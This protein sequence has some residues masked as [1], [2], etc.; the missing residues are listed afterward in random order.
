ML[1]AASA[2]QPRPG[3]PR[4]LAISAQERKGIQDPCH[5]YRQIKSDGCKKISFRRC[6]PCHCLDSSCLESSCF[7]GSW[8][9]C[10]QVLVLLNTPGCN[11][12]QFSCC[13]KSSWAICAVGA[14]QTDVGGSLILI[15]LCAWIRD[16]AFLIL[17]NTGK[18][19]SRFSGQWIG[20]TIASGISPA[21]YQRTATNK[22]C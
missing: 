2:Q 4:C 20:T 18:T 14:G 12:W 7:A 6:P 10:A 16:P 11:L 5:K 8:E 19:D 15:C 17:Y 3:C 22:R 21:K 1:T 13:F 9:P